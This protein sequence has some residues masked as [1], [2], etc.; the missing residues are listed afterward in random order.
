[1][2][3][4]MTIVATVL[5]VVATG[6]GIAGQLWPRSATARDAVLPPGPPSLHE[7]PGC[8][9]LGRRVDEQA[10]RIELFDA[11]GDEILRALSREQGAREERDRQRAERE[12]ARRRGQKD[13]G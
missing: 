10:R 4:P 2:A 1:M 11:K 3:E 6:I 12:E 5:G 9:A 7:C 8:A 13:S